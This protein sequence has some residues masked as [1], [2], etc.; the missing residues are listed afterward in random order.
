MSQ[1]TKLTPISTP[2]LPSAPPTSPLV[3]QTEAPIV[4]HEHDRSTGARTNV[5]QKAPSVKRREPRTGRIPTWHLESEPDSRFFWW[6]LWFLCGKLSLYKLR[7]L[8]LPYYWGRMKSRTRHNHLRIWN[9]SQFAVSVFLQVAV[10]GG[11]GKTTNTTWT[12]GEYSYHTD[13]TAVIIDADS[14]AKG[15][16]AA[17]FEID[18]DNVEY[19]FDKVRQLILTKHWHPTNREISAFLPRDPITGVRVLAPKNAL[20]LSRRN[21]A[22]MIDRLSPCG[23]VF[24]DTTPGIKE[25]N[26]HGA[27]KVAKIVSVAC[28]FDSDDVVRNIQIMRDDDSEAVTRFSERLNDGTLFIVVGDVPRRYFNRR[29]QYQIADE[30]GVSGRQI[31]L[32]PRDKHIKRSGHVKWSATSR[33]FQYAI[34]EYTRTLVEAAAAYNQKHPLKAPSDVALAT[35]KEYQI[36][37]CVERLIGLTGSPDSAAE[38]VFRY[39]K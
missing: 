23:S 30:L 34:S 32:L 12:A 25:S 11:V 26:T 36:N 20:D 5:D 33:R 31:V 13:N 7:W 37:T 4:R 15:A 6:F 8:P 21:M 3:G 18:M 1:T 9:L 22:T 35:P 39:N 27:W 2:A 14:G 19:D 17:R 24:I 38:Q 28:L 16:A 10:K 29:T